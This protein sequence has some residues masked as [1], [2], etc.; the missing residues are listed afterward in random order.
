V[1]TFRKRMELAARPEGPYRSVLAL[2]DTGSFYTWV[3][4]RILRDLGI[5]PAKEYRF[6]MANGE[7]QER[8]AAEAVVRLDGEIVHTMCV[9]GQEGDLT[10]LGAYTLEGF[11]LA[12][13]PANKKLVPL[14]ELPAATI[15]EYQEEE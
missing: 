11:A 8:R 6:T 10:L 12:V 2:V 3:P 1:G 14:T 9:F 5:A 7:I 4:G 13:D 15:D